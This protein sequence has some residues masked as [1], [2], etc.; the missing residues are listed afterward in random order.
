MYFGLFAIRVL[1]HPPLLIRR[2]HVRQWIITVEYREIG[3]RVVVNV[4]E[5]VTK[6]TFEFVRDFRSVQRSHERSF[7]TFQNDDETIFVFHINVR[8]HGAK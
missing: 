7:R 1:A 6:S 2:V 3:F 5:F 4:E 8:F